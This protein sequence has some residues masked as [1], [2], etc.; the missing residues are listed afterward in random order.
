MRNNQN[1]G[2]AYICLLLFFCDKI[3]IIFLEYDIILIYFLLD[4]GVLTEK[5]CS[6][7]RIKNQE[8]FHNQ[9]FG[10]KV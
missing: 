8:K 3:F 1:K 7:L 5:F 4:F 2:Q 9:S 10:H 6:F